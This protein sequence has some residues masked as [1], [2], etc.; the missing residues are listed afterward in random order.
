[1]DAERDSSDSYSIVDTEDFQ[2][3]SKYNDTVCYFEELIASFDSDGFMAHFSAV[4]D[5]HPD[6]LHSCVAPPQ[7]NAISSK[8]STSLL[9]NFWRV[10]ALMVWTRLPHSHKQPKRQHHMQTSRRAT[11]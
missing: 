6:D 9:I 7:T 11:S 2:Y 4:L 3:A 8:E 10:W 1:M 5:K